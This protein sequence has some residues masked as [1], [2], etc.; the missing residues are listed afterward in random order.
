[1]LYVL[2]VL[3]LLLFVLL[4]LLLLLLLPCYAYAMPS[5]AK[6]YIEITLSPFPYLC[7]PFFSFNFYFNNRSG[8]WLETDGQMNRQADM[9]TCKLKRKSASLKV[10]KPS[11]LPACLPACAFNDDL[12]AKEG[13]ICSNIVNF[14]KN[15]LKAFSVINIVFIIVVVI[16]II[17]IC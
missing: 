16:L 4:L 3:L 10:C 15:V 7:S 5:H 6:A 8:F 13:K 1:M 12:R 9:H 2:L 11:C 17:V 14:D